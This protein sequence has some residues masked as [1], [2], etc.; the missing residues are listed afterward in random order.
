MKHNAIF[1]NLPQAEK[2][3]SHAIH[4]IHIMFLICLFA[5]GKDNKLECDSERS[6]QQQI[7]FLSHGTSPRFL[8]DPIALEFPLLSIVKTSIIRN[9]LLCDLATTHDSLLSKQP[10]TVI[11]F[12]AQMLTSFKLPGSYGTCYCAKVSNYLVVL[13]SLIVS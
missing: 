9:S 7:F 1:S 8:L 3:I 6:P 13:Y 5:S 2:Q 11:E 4:F 10:L 12:I